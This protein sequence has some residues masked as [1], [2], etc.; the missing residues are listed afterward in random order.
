MIKTAPSVHII[1]LQQICHG[2]DVVAAVQCQND[3]GLMPG[4]IRYRRSNYTTIKA[5]IDKDLVMIRLSIFFLCTHDVGGVIPT[6]QN[7]STIK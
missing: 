2:I 7:M 4:A 6:L 3:G 5:P 1:N